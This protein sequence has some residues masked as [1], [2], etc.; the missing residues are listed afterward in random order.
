MAFVHLH[1]HSCYSLLDGI[2]KIEPMVAKAK[3]L[4]MPAL[5]LTD[6]G[7][8]YGAI[9]FYQAATAAGIK[10]IIGVEAYIAN[11]SRHDKEPNIDN[12]RFHLTLLAANQTGYQNLIK[13]VT[14]A[15]LEGYYY[16]PRM[17]KELLRQHHEGLICLS[18]C[19]ASE[20][21]RALGGRDRARAEGVIREHQEIFGP[22]NYFLEIMHHPKI[23]GQLAV[24]QATIDLARQLK[25]ALAATQDCHYL[26]PAEAK[27]H[28]IVVAVGTHTEGEDNKRFSSQGEDFS[29]I[30]EA[31]ARERFADIPEALDATLAIAARCH[32]ELRL[33]QWSFP[34]FP[35]PDGVTPDR[36][37]T[38]LT[39]KKLS[40][41]LVANPNRRALAEE[42]T[43]R[44]L[45]VVIQKGYSPYFLVVADLIAFARGRGIYTNTRG[46]AAGSFVSYLLGITNVDP[47]EYELPFERF[48]N[49]DRPSPPDIDMDFADKRRDEVIEYAKHKYGVDRVAQIGTFGS[50]MAKAAVR[51]IARAMDQ[52][53]AVGD[54]LANLIPFGSQGFPMTIDRA[55]K[56]TPE[57]KTAYDREP[58]AKE[59]LD[60]AEKIEGNPRHISVHAAGVVIAPTSLTDF[61]PLQ[62]DPKG[63]PAGRQGGKIITQYDMYAVE[64]VGLLKFDFLGIRNLSILEDAVRLIKIIHGQEIN[65]ERIPLDDKKTFAMLSRGETM[66][67]FQLNGAGMTKWLKD[68]KPTTI[69]DINVMIALYRPGPMESIPEY[70]KR[71]HNQKLIVYLD[72]R[73]KEILSRT[74]GI[75]VYQEDVMLIAIK[76]G[77]YSWIE[78][79]KLRK[80]MG[81]KIPSE[82]EAQKEKLLKGFI[83]NGLDENKSQALWQLIEPFAAYGFGKAHAASYGRLAYQTSYLKA[84]YPTEYMTA[85]L[86]A[87]SGDTATVAEVIN[88]C[89]RLRIAV[90]PPDV[91]E[92][93]GDFTVIKT[94]TPQT[95][96]VKGTQHSVSSVSSV[97]NHDKIRFGL[98]TI[99]NLGTDTA[100]TIVAERKKN[101]PF[102]SLANFLERVNHKNLNKKSLEALAKAGALDS[103][104]VERERILANLDL[105][106]EF[107]RESA[108][109]AASQ[110][111]L[112]EVMSDR[113]T[114]PQL[115]LADVPTARLEERLAWEKEFLGLYVSG[116]PLEKFRAKF[117]AANAIEKIKAQRDGTP[118]AA[119]GVIEEVKSILTK[120]GER[121]AFIRLADFTDKIEGVI[122]SRVYD[123]YKDLIT[124]DKCLAVRG[125]LSMRNNEPSIIVEALKEL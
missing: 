124:P 48:L 43:R 59:I 123:Q 73:M 39:E 67:L 118:A 99:K 52:P 80:A 104:G 84:N 110:T 10:P 41:H 53:Y 102:I 69:H 11:R 38:E 51:D 94:P 103:L 28:D 17:D 88:E 83:A 15:N 55:R 9:D 49:P 45:A 79:D 14:A 111:S 4:G 113:T 27:A 90:L 87:E 47:L 50:M 91:N 12:K 29:F 81:K 6:H 22:E 8:L 23:E 64:E 92:S 18:G 86:S 65:I 120:R 85:V 72:P 7:N 46:S 106:L 58:E 98:Y 115:K 31:T 56:I 75:I 114:V 96:S 112:F 121:M 63:L 116:H 100:E 40:D 32:L 57:L 21:G 2:S 71:K 74:F 93:F 19:L 109:A 107:Q 70:V 89:Q 35:L 108:R 26:E 78:A 44:E 68:L 66:G 119:A 37:L 77:G 36:A 3:R 76:L 122:F 82:M 33:G 30:D 1:N 20:L 61:V 5:A 54:R 62:L 25:I 97:S 13:L 60:I 101:G 16:K 95:P 24:K 125:R 42:R 105:V 117:N 34:N